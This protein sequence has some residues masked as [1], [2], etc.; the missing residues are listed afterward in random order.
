MPTVLKQ[1]TKKS[2]NTPDGSYELAFVASPSFI[3]QGIVLHLGLQKEASSSSGVNTLPVE[4]FNRTLPDPLTD[5]QPLFRTSLLQDIKPIILETIELKAGLAEIESDEPIKVDIPMTSMTVNITK[6][7]VDEKSIV[8]NP[9][10]AISFTEGAIHTDIIVSFK[11]LTTYETSSDFLPSGSLNG[12]VDNFR[13]STDMGFTL[14]DGTLQPE[15][16]S[17]TVS[18]EKVDVFF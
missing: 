16:K 2:I 15:I 10:T 17:L 12:T 18:L 14:K 11:F 13:I 7:D 9:D 5:I 8:W 6:F 4:G 3:S 1:A